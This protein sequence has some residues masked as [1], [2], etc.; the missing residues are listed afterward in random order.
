[1]SGLPVTFRDAKPDDLAFILSSWLK[2]HRQVG[3]NAWMANDVYYAI[4]RARFTT[5]LHQRVV[6]ACDPE[7]E[8]QILGWACAGLDGHTVHYVYVKQ[9]FRRFGLARRLVDRVTDGGTFIATHV[10]V[11]HDALRTKFHVI[12]DP[13]RLETP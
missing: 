12:Y 6:V 2:S 11:A 9:V 10:G 4:H 1:M 13:S 5:A 3:D 7:H 8:D